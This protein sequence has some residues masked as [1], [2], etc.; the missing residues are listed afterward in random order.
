ML[1]RAVAAMCA[2][3]LAAVSA[4]AQYF[5]RNKVQYQRFEF[6]VLE[7]PHFNLHYYDDEADAAQLAARLAERWYE[8]LSVLFD[9]A[10]SERQPI[11][12]YASQAHFSATR[13]NLS[14]GVG[15]EFRL[16]ESAS[17]RDRINAHARLDPSSAA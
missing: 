10:F 2:L 16:C 7:T 3:L 14:S 8:R 4:D 13:A 9:H 12:L 11:I 15:I 17:E 6:R 5:G 1:K